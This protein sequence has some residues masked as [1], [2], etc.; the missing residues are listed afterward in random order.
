MV[1][2]SSVMII[3]EICFRQTRDLRQKVAARG[4]FAQMTCFH[5]PTEKLSC[6]IYEEGTKRPKNYT[7]REPALLNRCFSI[8]LFVH[9]STLFS[10][11]FKKV[12]IWASCQKQNTDKYALARYG[13]TGESSRHVCLIWW[14][15]W[16]CGSNEEVNGGGI[17]F[18]GFLAG[19]LTLPIL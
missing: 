17:C 7:A 1:V 12:F 19:T 2:N 15:L 3:L 4:M 16:G 11:C 5:K 18:L 10:I 8:V 14:Q 6:Q 13:E 9:C